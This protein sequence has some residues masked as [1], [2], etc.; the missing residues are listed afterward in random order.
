MYLT[1]CVPG[2]DP[3]VAEGK[4][5]DTHYNFGRRTTSWVRGIADPVAEAHRVTPGS[6]VSGR[7]RGW[8]SDVLGLCVPLSY[9][10][11]PTG[12]RARESGPGP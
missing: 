5:S 3:R 12:G 6:P 8:A 4:A 7:D 2:L 10:A 11:L 9:A 1:S